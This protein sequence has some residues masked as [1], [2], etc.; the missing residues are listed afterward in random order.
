MSFGHM[1]GDL[2]LTKRKQLHPYEGHKLSTVIYPIR[3]MAR[4]GVRNL[5][6]KQYGCPCIHAY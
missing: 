6:S 4:L 3:V 1:A 5:I 2:T